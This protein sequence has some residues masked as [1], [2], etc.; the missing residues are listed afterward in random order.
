MHRQSIASRSQFGQSSAQSA[1]TQVL[2]NKKKE[3]EAIS[4][5]EQSCA[6]LISTLEDMA[7][8]LNTTAEATIAIGKAMEHW[9]EMFQIL[10]ISLEA[11]SA[12]DHPS[13]P[14]RLVRLSLDA[15]QDK[16]TDEKQG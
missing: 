10:S 4:A 3:Y 8:D 9:T 2:R 13:P 7:T 15:L 11:L 5:L 12:Q 6:E 14:N 16:Q 1:A